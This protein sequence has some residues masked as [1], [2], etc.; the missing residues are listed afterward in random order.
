MWLLAG[1]ASC[2]DPRGVMPHI[3]C[4][5]QAYMIPRPGHPQPELPP[6]HPLPHL[7]RSKPTVTAVNVGGNK[8]NVTITPVATTPLKSY[9]AGGWTWYSISTQAGS[10]PANQGFNCP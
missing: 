7:S 4:R 6:A 5:L 9:P 1:C 2:G 3:T 8:Y 10:P